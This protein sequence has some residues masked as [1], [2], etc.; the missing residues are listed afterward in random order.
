MPQLDGIRG[1]AI[2][3]VFLAHYITPYLGMTLPWG[4]M[5]VRLFFV[6]SGFLIT[7]IL[8]AS[9]EFMETGHQTLGYTLRVFYLRRSLR[10]FALY[11][12][13]LLL[14]MAK[15]GPLPRSLADFFYLSNFY[16]IYA[17]GGY[18]NHYWSL[19]VEEQFYLVWPILVLCLPEKRLANTFIGIV[20]AG[21]SLRVA[22]A[23]I[24]IPYLIV[25]KFPLTCFD[26]FALGGLVALYRQNTRQLNTLCRL[27]V[28]LGAP[29]FLF[30]IC[31]L[32][33]EGKKAYYTATIHTGIALLATGLI[34]PAISGYRGLAGQILM[35]RPLRYLGL[36]SYGC[37]LF[38]DYTHRAVVKV[39]GKLMPFLVEQVWVMFFLSV[40]LTLVV[41]SFSY[42][43]YETPMN[44]LKRYFPMKR[45]VKACP[46]SHI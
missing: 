13:W 18:G 40:T 17:L 6:L 9:R 45:K 36:V 16:D 42:Y 8:V 10:I 20:I 12:A 41:A 1:L 44:S 46:T 7:S 5:G 25:K 26:A 15:S 14:T 33:I 19:A 39:V 34:I 32:H 22:F 28:T 29:L 3:G 35:W 38:H 43:F 23:C 30:G 24:D 2:F 31:F 11:Y 37:Y 21:F 27:T 4:S